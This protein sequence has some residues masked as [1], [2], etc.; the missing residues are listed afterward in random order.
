MSTTI[1]EDRNYLIFP[2]D[3]LNLVDFNQV[4]ETSADTVRK[5]VDG[6]KTFVKWDDNTPEFVN[7]LTNTAGPYNYSEMLNILNTSEW[8]A[9]FTGSLP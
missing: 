2:V 6:T 3:Q 9:P 1:Y 7:T 4:H 5:S 8:T